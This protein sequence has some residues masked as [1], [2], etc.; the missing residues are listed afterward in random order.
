MVSFILCIGLAFS[1]LIRCVMLLVIP[2]FFTSQGRSFLLMYAMVL[3]MIYPVTNFS[4]NILVMSESATCG[5]GMALNE[6][7]DLV[8]T[9]V[10]PIASMADGLRE[11][12]KAISRFA[13]SIKRAFV[14]M[15][16][17]IQE[18]CSA[19]ARV[20]KWLASITDICNEN[21]GAPYKKCLKAFKDA[22]DDCQV[23][24]G[25]MNFLC[26]IVDI[27][28]SVCNVARIGELLCI[29]VDAVVS[30]VVDEI[31]A[32]IKA[33]IHDVEKMFYFNVSME[34][35]YNLTM[36]QS[37]SYDDVKRDI[38]NDV[39]SRL[40]VLDQAITGA[41]SIMM[42]TFLLVFVRA[43][44]YRWKYLTKDKYDNTYMTETIKYI[45]NKRKL[46]GLPTIL[47]LRTK[48]KQKYIG[49]FSPSFTE[50]EQK[51]LLKGIVFLVL[52]II[53]ASF[54]ILS[55]YSLYW[56]LLLIKEQLQIK[57]TAPVPAHLKVHVQGE[58]SM[59]DMYRSMMGVLDP[60]TGHQLNVDTTPCMPNPGVPNY[61]IYKIVTGILICCLITNIFEA[62]GLRLRHIIAGCYY[63]KRDHA[64]AIWLYNRILKMRGK[65]KYKMARMMKH[66][67][68]GVKSTETTS[69]KA[70][71]AIQYP[72]IGKVMKFLGYKQKA[73]I[74]CGT[75]GKEKDYENFHHCEGPGCNAVYCLD[76]F[77][78]LNNICNIC[79][80]ILDYGEDSDISEE[81]DSSEDEFHVLAMRE[82]ARAR[83]KKIE[84]IRERNRLSN[85][86]LEFRYLA[87]ISAQATASEVIEMD[88]R[89]PLIESDASTVSSFGK[90]AD[91][92]GK[93]LL[94]SPSSSSL[95][96][97]TSS[98]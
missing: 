4:N 69:L 97:L 70:R 38:M 19:I 37:K 7:K 74:N 3:V 77:V 85:T 58:G 1:D 29:V 51:K 30:F 56:T 62:Y 83:K 22:S 59:A 79:M 94:L 67:Y 15:K 31:G 33:A 55:D 65:L 46:R 96:S 44:L 95:S 60:V 41:E 52:N 18:I 11:M 26:G 32:P 13:R 54:Y 78:D 21:M 48:E 35:H 84:E 25:F 17:A 81:L 86:I 5:Q 42:F 20:F 73:C 28:A 93:G 27:V 43:M 64:R 49:T 88:R 63:P 87:G 50:N 89:A 53:N 91:Q 68:Q 66:K 9:A 24:L 12:L 72:R 23:K 40:S 75:E 14:A 36:V 2:N 8:K 47:P 76:C 16:N 90:P 57:T 39:K 98:D 80:N 61:R 6:T 10:S 82:K 45:D 34:Y 92:K 71:I